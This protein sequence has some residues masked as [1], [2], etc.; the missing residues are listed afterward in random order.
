MGKNDV[1]WV[2]KDGKKMNVDD[3]S[4]QHVRNAFK[5]VLKN[6][7]TKRKEIIAKKAKPRTVELNGDMAQQFNDQQE[8]DEFNDLSEFDLY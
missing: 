2:T 5:M 1:Y 3:M 7:E 4:D 6:I 8:Y